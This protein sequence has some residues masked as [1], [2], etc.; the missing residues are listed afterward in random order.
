MIRKF[1]PLVKSF[2]FAVSGLINIFKTQRNARVIFG[3]GAIAV[4]L[5]IHLK[6]S[7]IEFLIIILTVGLV[8]ISEIFNTIVEETHNFFTREFHPKI[9]MVK[10]MAAGAVL[11]SAIIS[12]VVA[13]FIFV[14]RIF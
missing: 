2:R 9:K 12:L 6:I 3:L 10:D 11:V 14:R 4:I 13:Y 7:R 1:K 8:F 5:G